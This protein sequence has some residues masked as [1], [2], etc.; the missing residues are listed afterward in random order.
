MIRVGITRRIRRA[1]RKAR[2]RMFPGAVIL[3]Y[4][5]VTEERPDP[6]R[7]AVSPEHFSEQMEVLRRRGPVLSLLE[8]DEAVA[9]GTVPPKAAVV[10]FDDGYAD[11]VQ[12]AAP[13][14]RRH[15]VPATFFVVGEA[16]DST[17]PFF[18]DE[19]ARALL[20]PGRLPATLTLRLDGRV[21]AW[22]LDDLSEYTPAQA[23]PHADWFA[24][25]APP[26]R[27]HAAYHSL[28]QRLFELPADGR[29]EAIR[30]LRAQIAASESVTGG[31]ALSVDPGDGHPDRTVTGDELRA[32]DG[33]ALFE[34][35]GHTQTH[36]SLPL[37]SPEAQ[38]QEIQTGKQTLER[39][40]DRPMRCFA[41]P[42]GNLSQ[43][44]RTLVEEA[45]F[46]CAC[47]THEAP[48]RAR[49][50]RL[51]LPRMFAQDWDGETF[52]RRLRELQP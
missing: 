28:W 30:Q 10:T 32:L 34:V 21:D 38:R 22:N 6:W 43:V 44:T 33:D 48:V 41:Y 20:C 36:P 23:R 51:E 14:L 40:L 2:D 42:F 9:S 15:G 45:G 49:S 29:V 47:S 25:T 5:R 1:V 24:E 3:M 19:L 26:T 17:E 18:W 37:L 13:I 52:A 31:P 8:L 46:R 12:T 11:N 39:H 27:R 16:I 50:H 7:L 4:H 35:G